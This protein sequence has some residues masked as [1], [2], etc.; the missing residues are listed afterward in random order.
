M[1]QQNAIPREVSNLATEYNRVLHVEAA[2]IGTPF[3]VF[4]SL[5]SDPGEPANLKEALSRQ[6][7]NKWSVSI[8]AEIMTFINRKAWKKV[9]RHHVTQVLNRR[10]I[11]CMLIFKRKTEQNKSIRYKTRIV[12]KGYMQIP[13]VDYTESFSPIASDTAIRL[14]RIVRCLGS[15]SQFRT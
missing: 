6:D 13:V 5:T 2:F 1:Q 8:K 4:A 10:L 9:L 7:R 11:N 14:I 15:F 3:D 12:S